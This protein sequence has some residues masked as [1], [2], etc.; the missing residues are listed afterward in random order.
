MNAIR[1]L[2]VGSL[3]ILSCGTVFAE[4]SANTSGLTFTDYKAVEDVV[5]AHKDGMALTLDVLTPKQGAKQIGLILVSSGSWKSGK[6]DIAEENI[7]KRDKDHWAQGLLAGGFTLFVVRHGS[8]PRYFVPEMVKD[9][10]RAVRF[11][12]TIAKEYGVD[13]DHLGI[14]S[15]SSGGHLSLMA[16]VTGDDGNPDDEDP[17]ERVSSRVQGVVA[18]FPPTDMLNWGVENGYQAIKLFRPTLFQRMFGEI[19]DLEK[20]LREIS[21]IYFVTK[22]APP[23][24]LIHGDSDTTVPLQQSKVMQSKYEEL[25]LPVKLIVEPGGGHSYWPGI[26]AEYEESWKWFNRYL[27]A[28][29]K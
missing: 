28:A 23:L 5:Y 8:S 20:Q 19:T 10:N 12:R 27:G 9:M 16:A 13:P 7:R 21:P 26:V 24:L 15:G 18:W 6:S 4:D 11:V 17:I 3:I 29:D 22:Q 14:T 2:V 1:P 25:G